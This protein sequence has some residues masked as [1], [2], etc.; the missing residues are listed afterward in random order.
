ME[1]QGVDLQYLLA[2]LPNFLGLIFCILLQFKLIGVLQADVKRLLD[3]II[4][5]ENC[6]D[7]E[8]SK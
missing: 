5:R 7:T 2:Q 1:T 3:V 6:E 8:P 4:K